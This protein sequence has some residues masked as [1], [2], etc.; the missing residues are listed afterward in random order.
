MTLGFILC[1]IYMTNN[2]YLFYVPNPILYVVKGL[3]IGNV[4][5]QHNAL[6]T[7]LNTL[8]VKYSVYILFIDADKK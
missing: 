5:H 1:C 6:M 2:P 7:I 4:I 8:C 3:F